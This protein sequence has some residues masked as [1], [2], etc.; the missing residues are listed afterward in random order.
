MNDFEGLSWDDLEEHW[1]DI[2]M[3][4]RALKAGPR[5]RW[6]RFSRLSIYVAET[7]ELIGEVISTF[8]GPVLL[9]RGGTE[10]LN[11]KENAY[12]PVKRS[13]DMSV[14]PV[15]GDPKQHFHLWGR[16]GQHSILGRSIIEALSTKSR[17]LTV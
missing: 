2:A 10:E 1:T 11:R 7:H 16:R 8:P 12:M 14:A 5:E 9:F 4:L 6:R 13:A 3:Q 15:T 17:K